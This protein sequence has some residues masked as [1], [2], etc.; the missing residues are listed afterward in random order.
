MDGAAAALLAAK[1]G[2]GGG[3]GSFFSAGAG[4]FG[5]RLGE[6]GR[7][8]GVVSQVSAVRMPFD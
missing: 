5:A 3:G 7:P 1:G 4:G 8:R 2:G 6:V